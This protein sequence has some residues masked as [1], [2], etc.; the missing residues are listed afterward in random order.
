MEG[1]LFILLSVILL[2]GLIYKNKP[3]NKSP[4]NTFLINSSHIGHVRRISTCFKGNELN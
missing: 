1:G 2:S 3:D 4:K